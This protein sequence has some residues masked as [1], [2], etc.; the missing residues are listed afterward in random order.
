MSK[1]IFGK[2][3]EGV[4]FAV[5]SEP[6]KATLPKEKGMLR[7]TGPIESFIIEHCVPAALCQGALGIW[8]GSPYYRKA[9]EKEGSKTTLMSAVSKNKS[10]ERPVVYNSSFKSADEAI[11]R[12]YKFLPKRISAV[13]VICHW[14]LRKG[15]PDTVWVNG[16]YLYV[17]V[18]VN[19][20]LS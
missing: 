10:S 12:L 17:E 4:T 20:H 11:Y 3:L 7:V 19:N 9:Y 14:N 8:S 16:V 6:P 15:I 18:N 1:E 5:N 13:K 2:V